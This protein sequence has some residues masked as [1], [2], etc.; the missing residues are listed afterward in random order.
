MEGSLT[1]L[2]QRVGNG[3]ER[4]WLKSRTPGVPALLGGERGTTGEEHAGSLG[5]GRGEKVPEI[6]QSQAVESRGDSQLHHPGGK[7][8]RLMGGEERREG[9]LM[10][11]GAL[12]TRQVSSP[13]PPPGPAVESRTSKSKSGSLS[14]SLHSPKQKDLVCSGRSPSPLQGVSES[15][16]KVGCRLSRV[17]F[18]AIWNKLT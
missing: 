13:F 7:P 2:S 16:Q 6:G 11:H 3:K 8:A 17:R 15:F 14:C 9:A 1:A 10:R 5:L 12:P 4:I 18:G